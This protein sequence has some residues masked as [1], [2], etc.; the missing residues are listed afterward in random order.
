MPINFISK[1]EYDRRINHKKSEYQIV[2]EEATSGDSIKY[3][4][5]EKGV[6]HVPKRML[7]DLIIG[8]YAE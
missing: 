5:D 7:E 6:H 2:I 4:R 8:I 1:Y 3:W